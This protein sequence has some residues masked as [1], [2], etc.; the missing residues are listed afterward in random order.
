MRLLFLRLCLLCLG[1]SLSIGVQASEET[2]TV[3]LML[4]GEIVALNA[5]DDIPGNKQEAVAVIQDLSVGQIFRD[6]PLCPE[7]VVLPATKLFEL[8]SKDGDPDEAP[9]RR[10]HFSKPFAI[11]RTEVTQEQWRAVMGSDPPKLHFAGCDEC[12]VERVSWDDVQEYLKKLGQKTGK[13]YRLPTESEWEYACRGGTKYPYCGGLD[14]GG[15]GWVSRN[16]DGRTHPVAQKQSNNFGLYDM[17]G[18]VSE[19]VEDCGNDSHTELPSDGSAWVRR[20]CEMRMHRGGSWFEYP[21]RARATARFK[22]PR[23]E[24]TNMVGFR[25]ALSVEAPK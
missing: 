23:K 8:G 11:A 4:A 6:C 22:S 2:G 21:R 1:F 18:N 19:W 5:T 25:V 17:T 7:M 16:S 15:V 24:Q 9:V 14:L 10:L 3:G 12:P 13:P 20:T